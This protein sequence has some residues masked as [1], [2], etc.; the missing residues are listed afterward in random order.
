MLFAPAINPPAKEQRSPAISVVHDRTDALIDENFKQM[1][2]T[3]LVNIMRPKILIHPYN[4][5]FICCF[6]MSIILLKDCPLSAVYSPKLK[7][8]RSVLTKTADH[9]H[10]RIKGNCCSSS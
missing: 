4:K 3:K 1:A 5:A 7:I 6:P 10:L 2:S 9:I 8:R